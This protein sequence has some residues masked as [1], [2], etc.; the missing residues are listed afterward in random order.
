L[1]Q[2]KGKFGINKVL[3]MKMITYLL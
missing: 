1:E 2:I 3:K